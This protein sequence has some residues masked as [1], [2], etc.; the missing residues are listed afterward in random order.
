MAIIRRGFDRRKEERT[1]WRRLSPRAAGRLL[2][3]TQFA[4]RELGDSGKD[5]PDRMHWGYRRLEGYKAAAGFEPAIEDLQSRA[6]ATWLCRHVRRRETGLE[7]AT[8]TLAR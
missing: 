1:A 2:S 3:R 8:L 7:P 5:G 4:R 6:L